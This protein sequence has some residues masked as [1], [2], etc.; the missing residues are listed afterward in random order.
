METYLFKFSACLAIF[1]L[2]YVLLLERQ[3]MHRFKRFYLLG[4]FIA[5][6]LIPSLT[7]TKYIE[8]IVNDFEFSSNFTIPVESSVTDV[9]IE[10]PP[11]W[12]LEAVLWLIYGL[13]VL[14]F[15]LRFIVNLAKMYH[16]ISKNET[17]IEESFIYVLLKEC[18]IPHSFFKYLFFNKDTYNNNAVPKEVLLHEQTHANQLH[19]L[20][21][22]GI[23][24]LQIIFWFHPLIYIFKHHIKLNHEFLADQAV[25]G[26]GIDT[27]TYQ[28]I[29]LQFSSST[30]KHQL[31]SAINYSSIKK[32]FTVM[33]TQ[34]SK[35]RI[36][37]SMLLLLP[38]IAI[39]FYSFAER[40]YVQKYDSEI[41]D[42]IKAELEKANDLQLVYTD[43]A[44]EAMM[45]EYKDWIE[46][47][48]DK[49]SA[50]FIPVGTFER[51]A[52]IYHLMNKA[53]R[54]SV[55]TYP[56]VLE[57]V[58]T[59]ASFS[60]YRALTKIYSN[61][62]Q[63]YLKGSETDN[64]ELRI[65]KAQAD[66]IYNQF[67][68]E[69]LDKY[70]I[71]P[72][73]PVPAEKKFRSSQPKTKIS[74]GGP[75]FENT[76]ETYNPTFLEY[77]I[78]M[79]EKGAS[80]YLD[81]EKISSKEAKSI[82]RNTKGRSTEMLTQK[83]TK[84]KYIVKLSKSQEKV[85]QKQL[86][87]YN[88]WAKKIH[89]ESK[90]IT[91]DATWFPPIDE[92]DLIKFSKIYKRMSPQQKKQAVDYPFPGLDVKSNDEKISIS[93][94]IKQQKATKEE[95]AEYN[96]L[97]KH[98]NSQLESKFP[99]IKVKDVK[100]VEYLYGIMSEDQK[101]NAE[102]YPDFSKVPPPPP[103][104][105]APER[106]TVIEIAEYD[107][108][109]KKMNAAIKKAESGNNKSYYPRIKK[110]DY[111]K[112]NNIYSN[113]MTEAHRETAEPWPNIPPPPPPSPEAPERATVIEIAEYDVWAKKL[114]TAMAK[115][116]ESNDYTNLIVKQNDVKKHKAIYDK[117][118][119][120]QKKVAE[121]WPSFPPPPPPPESP[122]DFV[123]RMA[124]T[125]AKFFYK[126]KPISSDKAIEILKK[127]PKLHLNA[128]KTDTKE[129]LIYISNKP[130]HIGE[131][132]NSSMK[133]KGGPNAEDYASY[134]ISER[135]AEYIKKYKRYESL[136]YS[137]P[138]FIKKSKAKKQ[139]MSDLWVELRQTYF[140]KLTKAEKENLKLPITPFA[141]YV[142]IN[143]DGKSYYKVNS[144]LTDEERKASSML[145]LK[146]PINFIGLD[147]LEDSD[148]I[149]IPIGTYKLEKEPAKPN[150]TKRKV[151]ISISEDGVY[152]VSQDSSLKNFKSIS[153][154]ALEALVVKLSQDEINNTFVFCQNKDFKKFRSKPSNSTE[155]Q[156]DIEVILVK[157][158]IRFNIIE[159]NGKY[160]EHPSYQLVLDNGASENLKSHVTRLTKL[161]KK[162]GISNLTI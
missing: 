52:A 91:K 40:E 55:G 84:G 77:I 127:N 13:G 81:G 94:K 63:I 28:N 73:P 32:R 162:H 113:L 50:L 19:S 5:A 135:K 44:S 29:L 106:A 62:I 75:N 88:T 67:T 160:K 17:I 101:K 115:A 153:L 102:S 148:P 8:P 150:E 36:W 65:L 34:T 57:H 159:Y 99:I 120:A 141:P 129:P 56:S 107:V 70:N 79:E 18:R 11:F 72:T 95:V 35:T 146:K 68:K 12:N 136:R 143:K 22:I 43:G 134:S 66:K 122:L 116:K 54:K 60:D 128:Q 4:A 125:N 118:T 119:E 78:E 25:L 51:L 33:K 130:I 7:I 138:H 89:D 76:Q 39:L 111:D 112:Y 47:L 157:D 3:K 100:R 124:K 133:E 158:D 137:K 139:L 110:E 2:I 104:P 16:R 6:L 80:F 123:I 10:T 156:N 45:K 38:I 46:K 144:Q 85:T 15:S 27:K 71:L 14:L 117:M 30:Q 105:P 96:K 82:A 59:Q 142:K 37:L 121:Q 42:P 74:R 23:E 53:Q 64:S 92:Q 61:A 132:G 49:S 20:D 154:K 97:A 126:L 93:P 69:D 161:F 21:I 114:N 26:K 131:K 109:A 149:V 152:S 1:W 151:L 41:A 86:A 48:N 103:P 90:P 87:E 83:D 98:C 9:P 24:I 108:W 155:Y 31:S 140:F 58:F 145:S 147:L